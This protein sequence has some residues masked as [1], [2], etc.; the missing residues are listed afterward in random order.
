[1]L[2]EID[3]NIWV[4]EQP[5]RYFG[6]NVGTRMTVIRLKNRELFVI[7]PIQIDDITNQQLQ[8]IGEVSYI[9]APNLYHYLFLS[10][11]KALYPKAK[12]WAVPGLES[13]RPDIPIDWVIKDNS[14]MVLDEIEYLL[15]DG[16]K[17]FTLSGLSLLNECVFFHLESHTLVLTDTAFHFDESFPLITQL[18]S[19]VIG[20]YK[21][22]S[23]SLLERLATREKQKVKQSVQKVLN[24]DFKRVIMAHGSIIENEAKS[25]FKQGYEWFLGES[26]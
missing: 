22:L 23:P 20:G 9:I 6:L 21:Q 25:K 8:E 5:F 19:R 24:W 11:F 15:F 1:M 14:G 17:T 2:R 16:F 4:S 18:A 7:S 3:N 10:D 13:K 26:L 12:L